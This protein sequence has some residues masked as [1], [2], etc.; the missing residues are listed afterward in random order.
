MTTIESLRVQ[1]YKG[2][3]E[4]ELTPDGALVIVAGGNGEGKSSFI[5]AIAEIIDPKGV[6][7]TAKPIRDGAERATAELVTDEFIATRTWTKNDA[8]K[9]VVR[10]RDGAQYPSAADFM[11]K[12]TG[13]GLFDPIAFVNL[14]EREQRQQLLARVDLPFDLDQVDTDRKRLYDE[15]TIVNREVTRLEGHLAGF[16]EPA[17][18]V[19][20][21]EVSA[22]DLLAEA[23]AAREHNAKIIA[24]IDHAAQ[25]QTARETAEQAVRDAEA[26]LAR[27][28]DALD[29]ATEAET[30]H[31]DAIRKA[32]D[33]ID[34]TAITDRLRDIEAT[35]ARVRE[36]KQRAAVADEL[37]ATRAE[38]GRISQ[39]ID[40]IDA[41][42]VEALAAAA[43]PVPG[44]SV[45]D[46]GV[47][48]NGIPFKQVNTARQRA[49][50]FELL[51]AGEPRL[52]LAQ[53]K[54]GDLLDADTLA[55]I[56]ALAEARGFVVLIER[57]RD[58]S[59]DVGFVIR[60]GA[61]A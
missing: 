48:Y 10:T 33:L 52:R 43:F 12:V 55:E 57:D 24:G 21:D 8:G 20:A 58:E 61:L 26:A 15:R 35:N 17:D 4:I 51:T 19:P 28:R 39:A 11:R 42:K 50:A 18:D 27:A 22:A 3:R 9:L 13:A 49:V 7:L 47:T 5:D 23:D 2:V 25:L 56:R 6:K 59:R 14:P 31:L 54:D 45:D 29:V 32:P 60:E 46:N 53:I 36:A 41:K 34:V 40:A 1:D 38:A 37:A 16:A 44:L 30:E